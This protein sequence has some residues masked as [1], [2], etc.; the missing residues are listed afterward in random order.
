VAKSLDDAPLSAVD[1]EALERAIELAKAEGPAQR[2]QIDDS[3]R[4]RG[5][6]RTARFAAY[7][8]QDSNLKLR[9]WQMA[10]CQLRGDVDACLAATGHDYRG[11]RQAA[12]LLKRLLAAGL[13]RFEPDP[14]T[15][16]KRKAAN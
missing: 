4:E 6:D 5:W 3:L 14:E 7:A 1:R 12:L 10:P 11:R 15:A 8:C 2:Q 13:S 9:P 16:L